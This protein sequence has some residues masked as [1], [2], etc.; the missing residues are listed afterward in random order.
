M[1]FARIADDC[2]SN[3]SDGEDI[4]SMDDA[5]DTTPSLCSDTDTSEERST[6]PVQMSAPSISLAFRA[7]L[8]TNLG[9]SG[10]GHAFMD[11]I[12]AGGAC[13]SEPTNIPCP[14][15]G[16]N[17]T[18]SVH[19]LGIRGCDFQISAMDVKCSGD[20]VQQDDIDVCMPVLLASSVVVLHIPP[21]PTASQVFSD[22]LR[23]FSWVDTK[24]GTSGDC[25]FGHLHVILHGSQTTQPMSVVKSVK[26]C[27]TR[28]MCS[29]FSSVSVH[30]LPSAWQ[31][32]SSQMHTVELVSQIHNHIEKGA[33]TSLVQGPCDLQRI[34][35]IAQ[36]LTHQLCTP[37]LSPLPCAVLN[38]FAMDCQRAVRESLAH[39]RQEVFDLPM[40]PSILDRGLR[41][42][43]DGAFVTF[44]QLVECWWGPLPPTGASLSSYL[45]ALQDEFATYASVLQSQNDKCIFS[46]IST[47]SQESIA[48]LESLADELGPSCVNVDVLVDT[49]VAV[50]IASVLA[51]LP[52]Q[53]LDIRSPFS[54]IV[55]DILAAPALK[56]RIQ[57]KSL[58]AELLS[59]RR[60][61]HTMLDSACKKVE[62]ELG[63][64]VAGGAEQKCQAPQKTLVERGRVPTV[65]F[66]S[67]GSM[68]VYGSLGL[69]DL[70]GRNLENLEKQ[71]AES[72]SEGNSSFI[73]AAL[74]EFKGQCLVLRKK[75]C[76]VDQLPASTET[77]LNGRKRRNTICEEN[78]PKR[79]SPSPR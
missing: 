26:S 22:V 30:V 54:R 28:S 75:A 18:R 41:L 72:F 19:R 71:L 34:S 70:I 9:P 44:A 78:S 61:I 39:F 37:G 56:A 51:A 55:A 69:D 73:Q 29:R 47:F 59:T 64:F 17:I 50:E 11:S 74:R 10:L 4:A 35:D 58:Q 43:L 25:M 57:L 68:D 76:P 67:V 77:F 40:S 3:D 42:Q 62:E 45:I 31:H 20:N 63:A 14:T 1:S 7:R 33:H 8:V 6:S 21:G 2:I 23:F 53:P 15:A 13:I 12:I 48:R 49:H 16:M 79:C 60:K 32:P 24:F 46:A 5:D 52:L 27:I 38:L 66:S 65:E 36:N